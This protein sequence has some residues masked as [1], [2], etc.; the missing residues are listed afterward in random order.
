MNDEAHEASGASTHGRRATRDR[1]PTS[2]MN[3]SRSL[4]FAAF[5][6][7]FA[8]PLFLRVVVLDHGGE[9]NYVPDTSMVR[10]ALGMARDRDF[11]APPMTYSPYPNLLP[12]LLMPLYGVQYVAGR[13]L[14]SWGSVQEFADHMLAHPQHAAWVARGLVA[15]FGALIPFVVY[16]TARV[17]GM[18][19][20]AWVAAWLVGTGLLAVQMSTHDRPWIPVAFFMSATA[21][22]AVRYAVEPSA[23]ALILSGAMAGLAFAAHTSGLGALAI[24]GCAWLLAGPPWKGRELGRRVGVGAAAVAVFAVVGVLA[25]HAYFLKHGWTDTSQA[26]G[27]E[28]I[29]AVGGFNIGG[30]SFVPEFSFRSTPRLTRALFGYDPVVVVLGLL[31]IGLAWSDRRWRPIAV[32]TAAWAAIFLTNRSDHVRYLLPITV[33]LAWPAGLAAEVLW[34]ARTGRVVLA[35]LLAVPL[36]QALRFDW[37]LSRPDTRAEA[38]ER[39][40]SLPPGARVAIDRYGPDVELDRAA[41]YTLV[42]LRTTRGEALRSREEFRKRQLDSGTALVPG[43]NAVRVEEL[44]EVNERERTVEVNPKL[45]ALGSDVASVFHA[46]GVTHRL[47]VDK[48]PLDAAGDALLGFAPAGRHVWTIDP[49]GASGPSSEAFLPTEMDFPLLGLWSVERPGPYLELVD[50]R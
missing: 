15:L 25:G 17:A 50:V 11:L 3:S 9:R 33:F 2:R 41:V 18:R 31:G 8:L 12:Y 32:F 14:G 5:A 22:F 46:L 4:K 42:T 43:V 39:L 44:F 10:A 35:V 16:R 34:R 1:H 48:R 20:G 45:R 27:A 36:V 38:E 7:L 40:A 30:V 19:V 29:T 24:T 37:V 28:K 47:R 21:Y 49:A 13:A 23:R 6:L 26:I